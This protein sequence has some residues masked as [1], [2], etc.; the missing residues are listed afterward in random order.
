MNRNLYLAAMTAL[1]TLFAC[2]DSDGSL[3]S[4]PEGT[5]LTEV[6]PTGECTEENAMDS[7]NLYVP[8][9]AELQGV[10]SAGDDVPISLVLNNGDIL[11]TMKVAPTCPNPAVCGGASAITRTGTYQVDDQL[12]LLDWDNASSP[13]AMFLPDMFYTL[14]MC[15]DAVVLNEGH[16]TYGAVTYTRTE[17][18]E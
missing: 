1:L 16:P 9:E 6:Q 3:S 17:G 2:G 14:K 15:T 18:A 12:I 8:Y 7:A 5:L 10:W 13:T 11:R 4:K